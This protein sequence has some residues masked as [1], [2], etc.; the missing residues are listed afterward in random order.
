MFSLAARRREL[1]SIRLVR[2]S[3]HAEALFKRTLVHDPGLKPSLS[4]STFPIA[5]A[6]VFATRLRSRKI[7]GQDH[8]A[9]RHV[10]RLHLFRRGTG[11]YDIP[12]LQKAARKNAERKMRDL[13]LS[14]NFGAVK[15]ATT[16]TDGSPAIDICA[17]AKGHDVDLI[18]TSTHGFTG[19]RNVLIGSVAE[20]V[21]RHAPCWVLVVPSHPHVRAAHLTKSGSAKV[22]RVVSQQQPPNLPR[23][24]LVT[25]KDRKLATLHRFRKQD[26]A[27]AQGRR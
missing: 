12:G 18:I 6:K 3:S 9:A 11:I 26:R 20:Q 19:F 24:N 16:F 14:V 4:P 13:D 1:C 27:N 25:R 22:N 23:G 10:S 17:F 5:H 8:F 7:W 2:F 21:V 15:F